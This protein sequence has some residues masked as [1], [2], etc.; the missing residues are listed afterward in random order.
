MLA[1][2]KFVPELHL[3]QP[4]FTHSACGSFSKRLERI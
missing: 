1:G 3:R 2:D 4:G